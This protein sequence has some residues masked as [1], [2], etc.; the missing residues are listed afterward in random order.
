MNGRAR[1][2]AVTLLLLVSL[3]GG[4][5]LGLH[6]NHRQLYRQLAVTLPV[7]IAASI[8]PDLGG[9]GSY[10][11][12]AQSKPLFSFTGSS[13]VKLK[14]GTYDLVVADPAHNFSQTVF[15]ETVDYTTLSI[16]PAITYT[17]EYLASLLPTLRSQIASSFF[18]SDPSLQPNYHIGNDRL[19]M[20]GDWYGAVLQPGSGDLDTLRVI[21]HKSN[22]QWQ[23]AAQPSLSIGEPS[24]QDIPVAVI[25]SV[26]SL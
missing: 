9:D 4:I 1:F 11:Y 12:N 21:L 23:I 10:N 20:L 8:Y 24:H 19:Y 17:D 18:A 14:N 3:G 15:K 13:T 22:G 5:A 6:Q 26:D 16:A 25:R 7:N 2:V